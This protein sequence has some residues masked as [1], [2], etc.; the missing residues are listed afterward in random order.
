MTAPVANPSAPDAGDRGTDPAPSAW[1]PAIGATLAWLALLVVARIVGADHAREWK[2][3]AVPIMG[4]WDPAPLLPVLGAAGLGA[5]LVAWLPGWCR[6]VPWA[7]LLV[8]AA[9]VAAAWGLALA[10][11][12]GPS[13]LD[14]AMANQNEYV[15]VVHRVDAIG[16]D[17]FVETFTDPVIL[18]RY[19]IHVEGHPLGATLVFVALDHVGLG[20]P[21]AATWFLLVA[22]SL[23]APAALVAARS[24]ADEAMARRAAP[25]LVLVPAAVWTV[26]SADALFAAVGA[27][28]VALVV[29]ATGRPAGWSSALLALAGG[30]AFGVGAELSYGLAPLALVPVVVGLARRRWDVLGFAALGGVAVV[31]LAGLAGFWWLD[32]LA[33]TRVRYHDGIAELRS[34]RYFAALG[35]PAAFGLAVGPAAVAGI[36]VAGWGWRRLGAAERRLALL[37][38]GALAAVAAANLSG[39]SKAEVERIW[40]PFVPW[41]VLAAAWLPVARGPRSSRATPGSGSVLLAGQ[42]VVALAVTSFV[43]TPW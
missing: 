36:A 11:V 34:Y 19:P 5:L 17:R 8:G 20:G 21:T 15:A 26:T 6:S 3:L 41:V 38:L 35:N 10:L 30:A 22:G 18:E 39:L 37:V 7:R 9:V 31:G 29:V 16:L 27:I 14:E 4:S 43:R 13:T 24:V 2:V 32:G 33:A 1:V 23:T 25:F 40:L 42:V 12:R 28:A